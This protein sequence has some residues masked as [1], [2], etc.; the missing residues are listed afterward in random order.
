[1][2]YAPTLTVF[3]D[4]NP[5]PRV[6]VTF[7]TVAATTA[8]IDVSKVVE[9]RSFPV[10]GGI[11]L[12]AVGGAYVMDSEPALGVPNTYRAEMFTAAGVSLGFTDAAVATITLTDVLRDTSEMVISQPLK[13]S[14][15]IR[16]SMGG[17]TAGQVVRS[18]PA[19]VVFPEGATVG[20]GIGG[21]LRGIVDMPLEVVC[22]TTADADELISMFGGYTSSFPPVLCI[23]TGAPVRLPRLLFASCSEIVETTIYA[24]DVRVRF[25]LKVTEVAPPA[26][27][28]VLPSLRRMDIDAAFATRA[29]RAAAYASRLARDTDYT[30]AGLAG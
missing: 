8:T 6:L 25:Q 29:A 20:V 11:G 27:G 15:A 22:E 24:A 2:A 18:I 10:R 5:S 19:E 23:R 1:M 3:T 12:Y 7:P 26:P 16:A 17:D 30:K 9:G 4:Y 14:L 21:Q 13:P 28:L